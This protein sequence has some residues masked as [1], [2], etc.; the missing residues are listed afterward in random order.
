M[1]YYWLLIFDYINMY[2]VIFLYFVTYS[3][4]TLEECI[5]WVI[6]AFQKR[7]NI[8]FEFRRRTYDLWFRAAMTID[9]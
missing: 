6:R 2:T 9:Q 1:F 7:S 8:W 5:N 3:T 4:R